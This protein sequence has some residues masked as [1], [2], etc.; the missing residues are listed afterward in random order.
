MVTGLSQNRERG[1]LLTEWA[2]A[3]AILGTVMIPLAFT[4]MQEVKLCRAC[5]YKA[6]AMEIIDGEM[7]ILAA[8]EWRSFKTG[9]QPYSIHADSAANLPPGKFTLTLTVGRARLEWFPQARGQG[10]AVSREVRLK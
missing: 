3:M 9:P 1:S 7:E 6:V 10:G 2:I 4:F 8:G 5:Y